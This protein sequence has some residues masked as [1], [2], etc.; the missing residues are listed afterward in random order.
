MVSQ[1]AGHRA[2]TAAGYAV[3]FANSALSPHSG[4]GVAVDSARVSDW[5]DAQNGGQVSRFIVCALFKKCR[6]EEA[7]HGCSQCGF[8]C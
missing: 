6:H 4:H 7:V 5:G 1:C 2:S 8:A 3:V